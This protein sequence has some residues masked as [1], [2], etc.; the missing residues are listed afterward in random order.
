MAETWLSEFVQFTL[1]ELDIVSFASKVVNEPKLPIKVLNLKGAAFDPSGVELARWIPLNG[2]FV[3]FSK[4]SSATSHPSGRARSDPSYQHPHGQLQQHSY[5]QT[6]SSSTSSSAGGPFSLP[7]SC[8]SSSTLLASA[9]SS[10]ME[11]ES[12]ITG[13]AAY[14]SAQ[15]S[16]SWALPGVAST[17]STQTVVIPTPGSS[18]H[19][20]FSSGV[21]SSRTGANGNGASGHSH[22]HSHSHN[23]RRP[24]H[25]EAGQRL[26]NSVATSQANIDGLQS[27]V[28]LTVGFRPNHHALAGASGSA[29]ANS[30]V[31][32]ASS[33][34]TLM[35]MN[36][37]SS[38]SSLDCT[39]T[40]SLGF[41]LGNVAVS[42][43]GSVFGAH[44]YQHFG[45]NP[46]SSSSSSSASS[47][48]SSIAASV[49]ASDAVAAARQQQSE[50]D[51]SPMMGVC[52]EQSPVASH[53]QSQPD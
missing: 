24:A 26:P 37:F 51:D 20:G 7:F 45:L 44:N 11:C 28:N 6:S 52:V 27:A 1:C 49:A 41:Q 48:P 36:V 38:P 33:E 9:T 18:Q 19:S 3:F 17:P 31:G 15:K 29:T 23:F 30:A 5:T 22:V 32:A 12:P 10:A 39:Q 42:Y 40:G 46:P 13:P 47:Q 25:P 14:R 2:G 53:W 35:D 50:R 21:A 8:A 16:H 34:V 43:T 4:A